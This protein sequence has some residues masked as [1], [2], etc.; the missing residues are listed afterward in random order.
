MLKRA[1]EKEERLYGSY[2]NQTPEPK[3]ILGLSALAQ[4]TSKPSI[5]RVDEM[6]FKSNQ[7][8]GLTKKLH[9]VSHNVDRNTINSYDVNNNDS[10]S[11][12]KTLLKSGQAS[13]RANLVKG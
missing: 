13:L 7:I 1:L 5:V 11:P 4:S 8:A 2:I 3:Y 12:H 9:G 10:N 6:C